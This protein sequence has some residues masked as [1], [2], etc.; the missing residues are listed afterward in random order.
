MT[1]KLRRKIDVAL[2]AKIALEV[3][4]EQATVAELTAKRKGQEAA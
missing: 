3:V 4:R 2:E 1:K